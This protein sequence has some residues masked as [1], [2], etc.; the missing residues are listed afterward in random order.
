M[1]IILI[2]TFIFIVVMFTIYKYYEFKNPYVDEVYKTT[3]YTIEY[4]SG[5]REDYNLVK[6]K[7]TYKNGKVTFYVKKE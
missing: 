2:C 1:T 3:T 7:R 5:S 6:Y 4:K